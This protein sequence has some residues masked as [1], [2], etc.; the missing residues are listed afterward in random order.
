MVLR[1]FLLLTLAA[2]LA[3][4]QKKSFDVATIKPNAENDMRI[5]F[6]MTP[7]GFHVTGASLRM[8][9]GQAYGVRDFQIT[10]GP[11]WMATDRYDINAKAEGLP[12][13]TPPGFLQPYIQSLLEERFQLKVHK[14]SKEMPIYVLLP[15]KG[16][17]K[18]KAAETPAGEGPGG[19]GGPRGGMIRMG[20]GQASMKSA[21]MA[22]LAQLLSQ[23]LG[24]T[25][26]DK[27][28]IAGN[29]DIELQWTPEPGQG[30]GP[31]GGAM[32]PPPD[33]VAP[34]D[35]NGPT[36]FT[37]IQEQL[38][39]KLDSAKGPVDIIVVDSASKP[40]EN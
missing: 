37:A 39:L 24:R 1:P 17:H 40:T 16:S 2:A 10:G 5:M 3:F 26:V 28:G 9:I 32:P 12:E 14:E 4:A 36:I 34:V 20:R 29:F 15:G 11:A 18:L 21:T 25:V 33:A 23:Q 22:S 31:F 19:P 35:S 6:R 13:R 38:G 8:L 7:G 27:T 30:V